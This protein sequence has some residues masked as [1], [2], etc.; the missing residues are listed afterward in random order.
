MKRPINIIKPLCL[1]VTLFIILSYIPL[2]DYHRFLLPPPDE[3]LMICRLS[4]I[5]KE[6]TIS[7]IPDGYILKRKEN[8]IKLYLYGTNLKKEVFCH[9]PLS[10][11]KEEDQLFIYQ[12]VYINILHS[13]IDE[14][15]EKSRERYG[16]GDRKRWKYDRVKYEHLLIDENVDRYG[17][18]NEPI[19]I[20]KH[21]YYYYY[22][23]K[24]LII[25]IILCILFLY[26]SLSPDFHG[27]KSPSYLPRPDYYG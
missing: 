23:M 4:N 12:N 26:I 3:A 14:E 21:S 2:F 16:Q 19:D 24:I 15:I 7:E 20:Y 6:A 27:P 17:F 25:V 9:S 8:I 11:Q 1:S 13:D 5:T 10:P 18:S 22:A